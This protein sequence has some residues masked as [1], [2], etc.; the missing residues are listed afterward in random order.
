MSVAAAWPISTGIPSGLVASTTMLDGGVIVGGVVS[1]TVTIWVSEAEFPEVSV[2][3]QV[4]VVIPIGNNSGASLE[5][6]STAMISV[7]CGC[8][9]SAK[10]SSVLMASKIISSGAVIFGGVVSITV[11]VCSDDTEFPWLSVAFQV[12]IVV[13]SGNFSGALWEIEEIPL[14]SCAVRFPK[15]TT[16]FSTLV[17]SIVI[18]CGTLSVGGVVS[19]TVTC[20]DAVAKLPSGS[21]AD[22]TTIVIP[23]GKADGA[24]LVIE[25]S[26]TSVTLTI[27]RSII[28]SVSDTAS[29]TTSGGVI[30]SGFV[31]SIT[32]T[33]CSLV[34][35]FPPASA[36]I[37]VTVVLPRP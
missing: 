24:S 1:L 37:H 28:F 22:Q 11:I 26:W 9:K 18:S 34:A 16:L 4:T 23:I 8:F 29:K 6:D 3:V 21:S 30:N 2:A 15:V 31:V 17:A 36:A 13:P 12:T 5:T 10:F 25:T 7:I 20:W 33:S 27:P 32:V 35:V 14:T 19:S